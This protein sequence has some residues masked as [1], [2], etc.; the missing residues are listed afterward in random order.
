MSFQKSL[1]AASV[2]AAL[3]A[4]GGGGSSSPATPTASTTSATLQDG[5]VVNATVFCDTNKNGTLDGGETSVTTDSNGVFT[6]PSACTSDVVSVAGTGIDTDTGTAPTGSFRAKAGASIVSPFTTLVVEGGLTDAQAKALMASLGLGAVDPGA[7]NLDSLSDAGKKKARAAI[8]VLNDLSEVLVNT[9]DHANATA[10]FKAVAAAFAASVKASAAANPSFDLFSG[11]NLSDAIKASMPAGVASDVKDLV[12]GSLNTLAVSMKDAA[13]D[14]DCKRLFA[15]NGM[16]EFIE[17]HRSNPG[18]APAYPDPEGVLSASPRLEFTNVVLTSNSV[19]Q[20]LTAASISAG[21]AETTYTLSNID[22][23]TI[24]VTAQNFREGR[25]PGTVSIAVEV[26][27]T[28]SSRKLQFGIDRV[29]LSL[30]VSNAVNATVPVG[31]EFSFYARTG[32][33]VSVEPAGDIVNLTANSYNG[34]VIPIGLIKS[35]ILEASGNST[36]L[37]EALNLT[38]TFD[39]RVTV[40]KAEIR[41]NGG[42]AAGVETI[43]VGSARRHAFPGFTYKGSINFG[44]PPV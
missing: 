26:T 39:I 27:Q 30:G 24:P 7:T 20:T 2:L 31:A 18:S 25:L 32:G 43:T 13:T 16:G 4:C 40:S 21:N 22:T 23:V 38:G 14:D 10:A 17:T 1:L 5:L 15:S 12:A 3:T 9:G 42:T 11:T 36:D 28:G 44:A 29:N 37:L 19:P 8:K 34:L 33:G 35:K 41:K 6:F